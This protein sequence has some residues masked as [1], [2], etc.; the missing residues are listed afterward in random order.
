[1]TDLPGLDL[2]RFAAWFDGACP[3]EIGGPLN[4]RLIAG[5]RSNLTYEVSD[6]TRSWVVRRPPLG[7]VLA[8]A[9]DMAREYRVI[10]ALRDTSVPVPRSYALC[11]DP[12]VLGA[13][14]YVM[15]AVDGIAYRTAEQLGAV[16]PARAHLIAERMVHTLALLHAV[17]PAAVGLAEFGRPAGFLARQ[18]RRWQKQ[19]DASRSRPLAGIDELHELLA[20]NTPDEAAATI[21]HGDYRLD[22][23][24]VGPDDKVAAVLDWE[25][26]TVGD[27]LTDV[28]LLIVYQRMDRLGEGPMASDAPGYPAEAEILDLYAGFS[29]RDLSDLGF[30]I[31]LAS[32]KTAVVLEGIHYRYAHGQTVGAGFEQIG[33]LVE[34][35]VA[36]GLA[37]LRKD[38]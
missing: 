3:G 26:A 32:F 13:P 27:P 37:A 24:L 7:H 16:G 15:S 1:M 30:Y 4:G 33:T 38:S 28:G 2:E 11:S 6:G 31:A 23:V 35:L 5:G 25:M 12:D 22:N 34:P 8:T 9:H 19:L 14:F 29:G 20:V 18:V 36:A 17:D 21:V 10:T